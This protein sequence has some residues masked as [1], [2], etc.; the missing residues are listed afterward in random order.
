MARTKKIEKKGFLLLDKKSKTYI[1]FSDKKTLVEKLTKI[2]A[3]GKNPKEIRIV[4]DKTLSFD[5]GYT[6]SI[7]ERAP[8]KNKRI[9]KATKP[10]EKK[11]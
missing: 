3:G 2:I 11:K 7:R 1:E 6:V 8:R 5:L 4:P 10:A 9:C